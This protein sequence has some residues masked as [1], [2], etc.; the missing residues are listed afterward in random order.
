MFAARSR[1][2]IGILVNPIVIIRVSTNLSDTYE[3]LVA[4]QHH[5]LPRSF[6]RASKPTRTELTSDELR[7]V[8]QTLIS[9]SIK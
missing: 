9:L 4:Q 3:G 7:K 1:G 5:I 8:V 6:T 2:H